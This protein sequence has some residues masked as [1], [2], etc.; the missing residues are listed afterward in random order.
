MAT[1][2][3][4]ALRNGWLEGLMV[5][6]PPFPIPI[7][8]L[9]PLPEG[10]PLL[11]SSGRSPSAIAASHSIET[12]RILNTAAEPLGFALVPTGFHKL[13]PRVMKSVQLCGVTRRAEEGMIQP[14]QVR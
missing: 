11:E 6:Y 3:H 2:T 5:D 8:R 9:Q 10:L 12:S 4:A 14:K 1:M 13:R 7:A